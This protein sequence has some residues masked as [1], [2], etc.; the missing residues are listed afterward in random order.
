MEAGHGYLEEKRLDGVIHFI[1][2]GGYGMSALAE[3]LVD[4]GYAVSGC[5][6]RVNS[7]TEH[8]AARGLDFHVGHDASHLAGVGAVV[9]S[10][11]VPADNVERLEAL[12]RG[13]PLLHRSE[14][15][16]WLMEQRRS[17]AVAGTHGKTTTSSMLGLILYQA[18][19]EPA[20]AIGGEPSYLGRSGANGEGDLMVAEACESDGTIVRYH[21]WISIVTNLEPE[22]LNHYEG[23]FANLKE[24]VRRFIGNT[25]RGGAVVLNAADPVLAGLQDAVPQGVE[26]IGYLPPHIENEEGADGA[27]EVRVDSDAWSLFWSAKDLQL[28]ELGWSFTAVRADEAV[29]RVTLSVPG[30]HNV[31][32]ALA[33][34]AAATRAG[35]AA[36]TAAEILGSYQGAHRRFEVLGKAGGVVIVDDYAHHPT[37]VRATLAAARQRAGDGRVIVLFQPQRHSR[38]RDL[39]E[40]FSRSFTGADLLY[41]ADIYAPAGDP[42]IP[43]VTSE[44]LA[45]RI[46]AQTGVQPPVLHSWSEMVDTLRRVIRP[47]DLV[48][49]MGAGDI[50]HV[51]HLLLQELV[52]EERSEAAAT[53]SRL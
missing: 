32:N 12:R 15:L 47:G 17:I 53:H 43:G 36:P 1:G 2:V 48:L 16:A 33:A 34:L 52:A 20:I 8:L 44:T 28:G 22:H 49:T 40:E 4:R 37:E 29:T 51:A 10:T 21:P 18:G 13:V 45:D 42:P 6:M 5:D 9:Y 11:D 19:L 24:A 38:T 39:M 23:D 3:I 27:D 26:R 41:L 25:Q 35:V 31:G 7:R 14:L 30:R 46:G 50:D